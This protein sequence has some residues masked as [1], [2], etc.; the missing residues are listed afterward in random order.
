MARTIGPLLSVGAS[1]SF[2][3]RLTFVRSDR[4]TN[5]RAMLHQSTGRSSRQKSQRSFYSAEARNWNTTA[6]YTP[7]G[8]DTAPRVGN[9][10]DWASFLTTNLDRW[11][12]FV[13]PSQYYPITE[14][15]IAGGLLIGPTVVTGHDVK[16]EIL[17]GLAIDDATY[18]IFR[19]PTNGFTASIEN[20]IGGGP[21]ETF[22]AEFF[23]D[24]AVPSGTWYYVARSATFD[25]VWSSDS[26]QATVIV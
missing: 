8:W 4:G 6:G 17:S 15:G 11:S 1:G 25:G 22:F 16:I 19:S 14:A 12:H 26:P 2:A 24:Q 18:W 9:G 21:I 23:T 5:V 10:S 13:A 7:I 3:S 20:L